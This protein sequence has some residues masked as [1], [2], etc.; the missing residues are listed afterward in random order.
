M[1]NDGECP[2]SLFQ[3]DTQPGAPHRVELEADVD[4][5]LI[6]WRALVWVAEETDPARGVHKGN[7]GVPG[8][9]VC[10][11]MEEKIVHEAPYTDRGTFLSDQ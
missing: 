11:S 8:V 3:R 6:R 5:F 1:F 9:V 2:F 4:D 10:G 7:Q